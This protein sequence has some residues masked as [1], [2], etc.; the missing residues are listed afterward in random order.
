MS[1]FGET[2]VSGFSF[3]GSVEGGNTHVTAFVGDPV[4]GDGLRHRASGF[5]TLQ[6]NT[7][8][9]SGNI[10]IEATMSRDPLAG[11]WLPVSLTAL[12]DGTVYP[13][14]QFVFDCPVPGIPSSGKTVELN[15]FYSVLGQFTWLR[16]NVSN[17]SNGIISSIKVAF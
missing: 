15:N 7:I 12:T 4:V 3:R 8:N 17:V 14:L 16:A 10:A 9:F 6:V 13:N 1:D 5:H 2:M 11:P